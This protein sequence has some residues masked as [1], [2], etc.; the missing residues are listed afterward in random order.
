MLNILLVPFPFWLNSYC[1]KYY[2]NDTIYF[3]QRVFFPLL[4]DQNTEASWSPENVGS[5]AGSW[6]SL[7]HP[8]M[9]W[10]HRN[11]E[12]F[13]KIWAATASYDPTWSLALQQSAHLWHRQSTRRDREGNIRVLQLVEEY[14]VGTVGTFQ[15]FLFSCRLRIRQLLV[16]LL[17]S[18]Q[19]LIWGN[20]GSFQ[21][22][23]SLIFHLTH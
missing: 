9:R 11:L 16:L 17:A 1:F 7:S 15:C 21:Q 19:K 3:Y 13:D 18:R 2:K 5:P 6:W 23:C 10:R 4:T 8:L 12:Q 20:C 14:W 22:W